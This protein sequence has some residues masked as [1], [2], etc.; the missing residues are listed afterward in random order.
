MV[1]IEYNGDGDQLLISPRGDNFR[2]LVDFLKS[3]HC[4]WNATLKKWTL[5]VSLYKSFCDQVKGFGE[6]IDI[7]MNSENEIKK[8]FDNLKE[9]KMSPRRCFHQELLNY[10]PLEGKHPFEKYQLE[11]ILRGINQNRFLFNHDMGLGKSYITAALIAIKRFY[12]ELDKCLI[13]ST[14]IGTLN[15]ADEL[16]KF[17]KGIKE[18]DI[19]TFTSMANLPF[20]E[21][22]VFNTKKY[23]QSIIIMSYDSLISVLNYYYDM[24]T[25]PKTILATIEKDEAVYKELFKAERDP[26]KEFLKDKYNYDSTKKDLLKKI[27]KEADEKADANLKVKI[28]KNKLKA[29][30]QKLHPSSKTDYIKNPAPIKEWLNGLNGGLFLDE[31]HS[32]ASPQ[33]RRTQI[34]N[35]I[36]PNFEYRYE[37]TGTLADKYQK[38]YEPSMIL[39]KDLVEGKDYNSWLSSNNELGNHFSAY[40]INDDKWNLENIGELNKKL[41]KSYA[42]RRK[43]VDCLDLPMNY[44]VPTIYVNMSSLHKEIYEKFSNFTADEKYALAKEEGTSFSD[45]MINMFQYMQQAVDNPTCLI[46]SDKFSLFPIDLQ[47]KIKEFDY[48]RDSS[49]LTYIDEIVKER[50]DEDGEKG[51]LWYFHPETMLALKE[52]YKDYNPVVMSADIPMGNRLGVIKSFLANDKQKIL[53]AS[54]NVMNTSVTLVECKWEEY[55]ES[56]YNYTVYSQSRGRIFRPGQTDITRTYSIRYNGTLDCLQELNL[57]TK[58]ATLSSLLNKEYVAQDLW[59]K[60]FNLQKGQ[61]I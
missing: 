40:A 50:V 52:R 2:D 47:N 51:I 21:R 16:V 56:T 33:S 27:N 6:D 9:L 44:E 54:I 20:E 10:P 49:K 3:C 61:I 19:I 14:P 13:F 39:D 38:L 12:K 23:P 5:S 43:M 32:L 15:L 58:G 7:D 25:R 17:V 22:D 28:A 26:I 29:D 24:T 30:K 42:S 35:M 59:R 60:M 1:S 31:V 37:F 11:D 55:V 48:N 36:L 41:M 8:F 34:M 18:S 45:K 57:K 53:I 4:R 46:K